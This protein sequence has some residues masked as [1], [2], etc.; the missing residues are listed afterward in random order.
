MK[1]IEANAWRFFGITIAHYFAQSLFFVSVAA[2]LSSQKNPL[3]SIGNLLLLAMIPFFLS[4]F[5]L[6]PLID[7][8]SSKR[9]IAILKIVRIFV[10]LCLSIGIGTGLD[11]TFLM[12]G[13][14]L[15]FDLAFYLFQST[16]AK[17][18]KDLAKQTSIKLVESLGVLAMQLGMI[19]GGACA[20]SLLSKWPLEFVFMLGAAIE[21]LGMLGLFKFQI[22]NGPAKVATSEP[23]STPRLKDSFRLL[24]NNP[25]LWSYVLAFSFI[26]PLMQV[27]N[28]IIGP[29]AEMH[30]HDAG[31]TLGLVSA[32][33]AAGACIGSLLLMRLQKLR[34]WRGLIF[35]P[36]LVACA[37]SS[38]HFAMNLTVILITASVLGMSL[39]GARMAA[40]AALIEASPEQSVSAVSLIGLMGGIV[41]SFISI[42]ILRQ[43]STTHIG[44]GFGTLSGLALVQF[45]C[46]VFGEWRK[47][48]GDASSQ[49]ELAA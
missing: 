40:R 39:A 36:I 14:V 31:H 37:F 42:L 38:L 23:A 43:I 26:L 28:L 48:Q 20:G 35:S 17:V 15:G 32:A 18:S 33:I 2:H 44:L 41:I 45:C 34:E 10:L 21:L 13:S 16:S 12:Y 25:A 49:V 8:I 5:V 1:D 29:W 19:L 9:Q 6:A 47:R 46:L 24:W 30:F 7:K 11:A 27:L 22:G 3:M 4:G